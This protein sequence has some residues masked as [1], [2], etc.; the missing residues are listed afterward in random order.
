MTIHTQCARC[1]WRQ[2]HELG[3]LEAVSLGQDAQEAQT[4]LY[5]GRRPEAL[6]EAR[7]FDRTRLE[8]SPLFEN[9]KQNLF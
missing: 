8:D 7:I 4:L 5:A 2:G 6:R 3:C 9:T 1:G